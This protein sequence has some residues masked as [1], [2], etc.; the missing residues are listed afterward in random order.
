M[1]PLE[2][3]ALDRRARYLQKVCAHLPAL[4]SAE[5]ELHRG[6]NVSLQQFLAQQ[7][8]ME[9]DIPPEQTPSLPMTEAN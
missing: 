7:Q 8:N 2:H 1:D 3:A 5:R 4:G 9:A 6:K